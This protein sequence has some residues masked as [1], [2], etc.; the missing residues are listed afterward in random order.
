MFRKIVLFI[1]LILA[2]AG[3]VFAGI[4]PSPMPGDVHVI[5]TGTTL[6]WM[7]QALNGARGTYIMQNVQGD[8]LFLW[9]MEGQGMG[10]TM[11]S[12]TAQSVQDWFATVGGKGNLVNYQDARALRDFLKENGWKVVAAKELPKLLRAYLTEAIAGI[13]ATK[14]PAIFVFPA[15]MDWYPVIPDGTELY[16]DS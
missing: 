7:T 12:K 10:F 4:S 11:V 14:I 8:I 3:L 6:Y 2:L 13:S 1:L 5:Q 9:N 16:Y 15:G